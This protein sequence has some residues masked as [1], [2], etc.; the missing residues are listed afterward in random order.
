M[1]LDTATIATIVAVIAIGNFLIAVGGYRLA[2]RAGLLGEPRTRAEG[3]AKLLENSEMALERIAALE[4]QVIEAGRNATDAKQAAHRAE[5]E[6]RQAK[7][8][9]IAS[10]GELRDFKDTVRN[11]ME[12]MIQSSRLVIAVISKNTTDEEAAAARQEFDLMMATARDLLKQALPLPPVKLDGPPPSTGP[13]PIGK[14]TRKP[15]SQG[16]SIVTKELTYHEPDQR[17]LASLAC[18]PTSHT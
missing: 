10:E 4:T 15:R 13:P 8:A 12:R 11:G 9:A 16:K 18:Q 5:D 17:L 2:R 14:R 7:E 1:Y 6:A 3:T